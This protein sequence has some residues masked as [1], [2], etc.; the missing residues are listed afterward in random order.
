MPGQSETNWKHLK[1]ISDEDIDISEI[2]PLDELFFAEANLRLPQG[3]E[4]VLLNVDAEVLAWYRR[5]GKDFQT[6]VNAALRDFAETH[7]R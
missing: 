2:P 1:T 4:S 6:L 7:Q 3:K 5:H